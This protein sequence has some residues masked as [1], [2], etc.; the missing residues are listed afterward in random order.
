MLIVVFLTILYRLKHGDLVLVRH[1]N[2]YYCSFGSIVDRRDVSH[3]CC[4]WY[5]NISARDRWQ[6]I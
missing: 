5:S 3:C 4:W 1:A 6:L 2:S